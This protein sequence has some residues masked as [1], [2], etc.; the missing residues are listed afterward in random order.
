LKSWKEAKVTAGGVDT[1]ELT[2]FLESK[3]F[4]GLFFI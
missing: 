4:P 2:K 1:N 3:K